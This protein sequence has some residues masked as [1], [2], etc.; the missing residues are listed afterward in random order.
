MDFPAK[1]R[2]RALIHVVSDFR[3]LNA[4]EN[5]ALSPNL[6]TSPSRASLPIIVSQIIN[7]PSAISLSSLWTLIPEA[8]SD[9]RSPDAPASRQ[10][11][12]LSQRRGS[13]GNVEGQL[14]PS[15]LILRSRLPA[16]TQEETGKVPPGGNRAKIY[17]RILRGKI[18]TRPARR[19]PPF[20]F[21]RAF[22]LSAER[23][24]EL[25]PF[26]PHLHIPRFKCPLRL[27]WIPP[28]HRT[29]NFSFLCA[30]LCVT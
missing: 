11:T 17:I 18:C 9:L 22:P 27:P 26:Y 6:R 25:L 20:I 8:S 28:V 12:V 14:W 10:A 30:P 15:W 5:C 13:P 29:A 21:L 1:F 19:H 3:R 2:S 7:L 16:R 4:K 24:G 23:T